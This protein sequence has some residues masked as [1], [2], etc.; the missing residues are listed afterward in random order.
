MSRFAL[1][2]RKELEYLG[3]S[4]KELA[5]KASIKKRALDMYLGTRASMPPADVAVKIAQALNVSVEYLVT[6]S[7]TSIPKDLSNLMIYRDILDDLSLLPNEIITPIKSMIHTAA[8]AE[9]EKNVLKTS[10]S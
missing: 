10:S 1:M 9:R 2:V 4:Q 6:G 5:D 3:L 7:D 8:E